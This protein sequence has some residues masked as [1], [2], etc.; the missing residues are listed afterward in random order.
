DEFREPETIDEKE[1]QKEIVQLD[2]KQ[3]SFDSDRKNEWPGE[4]FLKFH[5][6]CFYKKREEN[7]LKA[8]A[9]IL[10]LEDDSAQTVILA[11]KLSSQMCE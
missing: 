5:N 4:K 3:I 1:L 8:Q 6:K 7:R 2:G 10:E 11:E 9:E